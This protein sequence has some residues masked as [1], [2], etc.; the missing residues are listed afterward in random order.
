MIK[1]IFRLACYGEDTDF[2]D[3]DRIVRA[4]W[5]TTKLGI[6]DLMEVNENE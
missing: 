5:G 2:S 1:A 3:Q 6:R 4:T